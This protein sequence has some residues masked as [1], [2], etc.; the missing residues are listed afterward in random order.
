MVNLTL[1]Y[2]FR[3]KENKYLKFIEKCR[4]KL[5]K[6]NTCMH[7][8]H[9]VPRHWIKS[10]V[11]YKQ[12]GLLFCNSSE[13]LIRLSEKDHALAHQ[14]LY[15]LYKKPMDRGAVLL[16]QGQ[17]SASRLLWR[18]S[19]AAAVHKILS[20]NSKNFWLHGRQRPCSWS[21]DFQKEMARRSM[22]KKDALKTRSEGGKIGGYN[23]NLDR[24][25]KAEDRYVFS[26]K[27]EEVLC[28]WNCRTGGDVLKILQSFE[29]TNLTRV[30]ALLKGKRK[31]AY[32]WSCEK[33]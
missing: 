30:T 27:K 23:R 12:E 25:I 9:I 21:S 10:M 19:G 11:E 13:N 6:P 8:H 28:C 24:A 4:N 31:T 3:T 7:W 17:K 1:F 29:K 16:L 22:L 20:R 32:G 18:R 33:I 15:Y 5:Y 14:I 2:W 26:Y